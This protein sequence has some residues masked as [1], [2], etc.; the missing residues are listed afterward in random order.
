M[1]YLERDKVAVLKVSGS[2]LGGLESESLNRMLRELV[3]TGKAKVV[4]D[5]QDVNWVNSS[6]L[7]V[8]VGHLTTLRTSGGDLKLVN[9]QEKIVS[10][11]QITKLAYVI[12]TFEDVE[13]AINSFL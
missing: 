9:P 8:L 5:L 10:L 1:K 4:L 7:G 3:K 11:L 13:S 12:D 6:G 2:L